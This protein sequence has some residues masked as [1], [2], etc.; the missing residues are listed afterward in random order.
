MLRRLI[1]ALAV[2]L[3]SVN[4]DEIGDLVTVPTPYQ[5]RSCT[6][7]PGAPAG[8][9][10]CADPTVM[11]AARVVR[12][13]DGD[14]IRVVVNGR[15]EPVRLYGID[16]PERG[17]ACFSQATERTRDLAGTEVRLLRDA[18]NRD[19]NGR[20]L[21]YVFTPDGLSIDASLVADGLAV[22]WTADGARREDLIRLEDMARS[23]AV[24]CLWSR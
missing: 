13:I 9:V 12:I 20:L 21:R 7:A 18:R 1:P 24:G 17:E 15:E 3:L 2:I 10:F 23:T 5:D 11:Q 22:A 4:C 14:T 6:P 8:D 19:R 16:T